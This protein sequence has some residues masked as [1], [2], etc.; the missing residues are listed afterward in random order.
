MQRGK[1]IIDNF[2][3]DDEIIEIKPYGCGHIN[4]TYLVT[5]KK[6]KYVIQRIN[7]LIFKKPWEVM[8]NII[9]ICDHLKSK[10]MLYGGN[11]DRETLT[12]ITA[13]DGTY[14]AKVDGNYYR[15]YN[16]VDDAITY[17]AIE[18]PAHF[19]SA[20][21]AYGKF[22]NM[23]SD[24][25][26]DRLH[27]TIENFHNTEDRFFKFQT[28]VSENKAGRKDQVKEEI[29]FVIKRQDKY[30]VIVD[31]LKENK[32]PLRVTHNDTKLNNVLM[33]K[34]TGEA[35]CVIDLDTVMP[36]LMAYDFGDSIRFGAATAAEDEKDISKVS[37]D[38]DLYATYIRGFLSACPELTED[39]LMSLP[40]GARTMTLECGLRFL[41]DYLDGDNYFAVHRPGHN[42]DR[43]R[44]QLKMVQDMEEKW[45]EMLRILAEEKAKLG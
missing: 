38:L 13:K 20:G 10:V 17:Q 24:F 28:A 5:C 34:K 42:L 29:D 27:E 21:K 40:W 1:K 23:L 36:G 7:H 11:P 8:E 32:I 9:N 44:T 43:C 30:G 22:Q 39:E 25:G 33:D 35:I 37:V 41:T 2:C 26:A 15:A 18:N 3:I 6:S 16:F 12:F 31:L 19:Y 14:L 45:D 4:D